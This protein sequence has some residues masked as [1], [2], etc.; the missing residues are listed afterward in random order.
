MKQRVASAIGEDRQK[1]ETGVGELL[2]PLVDDGF[3]SESLEEYGKRWTS[4]TAAYDDDFG[5][6]RLRG[7]ASAYKS[8]F[9]GRVGQRRAIS[10]RVC[11]WGVEGREFGR[12]WRTGF[13]LKDSLD[14]VWA[15]TSWGRVGE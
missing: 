3:E 7:H 2:G 10:A 8:K 4:Y 13:A 12:M 9:G 6:L 1:A 15:R 14:G 5:H 11:F